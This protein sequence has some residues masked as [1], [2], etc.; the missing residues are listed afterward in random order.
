MKHR[1]KNM[2]EVNRHHRTIDQMLVVGYKQWG[3]THFAGSAKTEETSRRRKQWGKII[4]QF[5]N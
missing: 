1:N 3:T 4:E 5:I 2:K